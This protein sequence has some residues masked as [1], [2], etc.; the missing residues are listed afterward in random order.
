MKEEQ[1]KKALS[2]IGSIGGK[3]RATKYS[4]EQIKKWGKMG[5]RPKKKKVDNST[6]NV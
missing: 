6:S 2:H 3:V 4:K 1:I 5:G